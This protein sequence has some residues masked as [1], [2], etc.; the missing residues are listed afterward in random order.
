MEEV[1]LYFRTVSTDGADDAKADS[2]CFPLSA[3][4]G[5]QF[6]STGG[7]NIVK[8]SF[9]SMLNNYGYDE[10]A[11]SEITSDR[12]AINLKSTATAR[13]F[14]RDFNEA[15][16]S[17]KMKLRGKFLVIGDDNAEALN[18]DGTAGTQYFSATVDN[19]SA[20]EIAGI[21]S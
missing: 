5:M 21:V 3:F 10:A 19:I 1:Y 17:A 18:D 9:R 2:C 20:I 15:I 13:E 6:S 4:S 11:S 16:D 8:L 7:V 12:V 14:R